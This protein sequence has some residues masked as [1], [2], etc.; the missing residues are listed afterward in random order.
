MHATKFATT[1]ALVTTMAIGV[2]V[3][4]SVQLNYTGIGFT[5]SPNPA[6]GT[7]ITG[8]IVLRNFDPT[9]GQQLLTHDLLDWSISNG[10]YTLSKAQGNSLQRFDMLTHAGGIA[11]QWAFDAQDVGTDQWTKFSRTDSENF[12]ISIIKDHSYSGESEAI[13]RAG[14]WSIAAGVPEPA[15]W[16]MMLIG[17]G[18][19]GGAARLHRLKPP[20]IIA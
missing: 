15:A 10:N 1:I 5:V 7:N 14:S 17:F 9:V 4:A 19:V 16:G 13:G 3:A 20:T 18:A 11:Y 2:P 6:I 12:D 8:Y